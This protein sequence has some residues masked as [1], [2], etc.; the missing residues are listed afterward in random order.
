MFIDLSC[1]A[2][3]RPAQLDHSPPDGS[4]HEGVQRD[5]VK[6][7]PCL[8]GSLSTLHAAHAAEHATATGSSCSRRSSHAIATSSCRTLAPN[9][10]TNVPQHA[11]ASPSTPAADVAA[12]QP[13][14]ESERHEL[15][16]PVQLGHSARSVALA[17]QRIDRSELHAALFV[18][19]VV[20]IVLFVQFDQLHQSAR[21]QLVRWLGQQR[22]HACHVADDE[23]PDSEANSGGEQSVR[24]EK[25]PQ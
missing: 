25:L 13:H 24:S 22:L 6:R 18:L 11:R 17:D 7:V 1:T 15:A 8:A 5:L 14:A 12:E 2:R 3:E 9:A 20:L 10:F 4:A 23:R 19:I 21:V 16:S